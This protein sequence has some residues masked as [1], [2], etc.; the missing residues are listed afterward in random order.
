MLVCLADVTNDS[1]TKHLTFQVFHNFLY[2]QGTQN[3]L[4][5][6]LQFHEKKFKGFL[7]R[8]LRRI[9]QDCMKKNNTWNIRHLV[10]ESFV[11]M[12]HPNFYQIGAQTD[13]KLRSYQVHQSLS[14]KLLGC[15]QI[16]TLFKVIP[17]QFD[18]FDSDLR[19]YSRIRQEHM[20]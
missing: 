12:A 16:W 17:I 7:Q 14:C 6:F 4:F 2:T 5:L 20:G 10:N 8:I 19:K 3:T 11:P 18:P 1:L 9:L 13:P 15:T